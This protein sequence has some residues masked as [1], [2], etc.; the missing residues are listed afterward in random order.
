MKTF[1]KSSFVFS[2]IFLLMSFNWTN[3]KTIKIH[4]C[5]EIINNKSDYTN[6]VI[7]SYARPDVCNL[8]YLG[9][10]KATEKFL[11]FNNNGLKSSTVAELKKLAFDKGGG[12]VYIYTDLHNGYAIGLTRTIFACVFKK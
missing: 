9:E 3:K 5:N 6:K 10:I 11:F 8:H 4:D 1:I 12:I 7:I 2:T